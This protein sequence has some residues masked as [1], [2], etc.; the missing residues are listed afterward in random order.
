MNS[1]DS[2]DAALDLLRRLN[3]SRLEHH[4]KNLI[5]L[6]PTLAEDL[7]SSVD[8]PLTIKRDPKDSQKEYLCCDYNRDA[9]SH[10]SPWSNE[11]FPELSEQDLEESPFPSE[12]LRK[13][14]ILF[15][16]SFDVYRD[17]YYEGGISSAYLWDVA[18]D[19]SNIVRDFAGVVL[20]KK[21][22][23]SSSSWDSIHVLEATFE[24]DNEVTYRITTTILLRLDKDNSIKLSGNLSR[25][26]EKTV[27]INAS[28][29]ADQINIAH[30]TN[31]GS[32][33][34]DIEYQMRILLEAVY[35]E[36]TRDIFH[37]TKN[38]AVSTEQKNKTAHEE[39]IKGLQS[40]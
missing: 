29:N 11:Y 25:Q 31:V 34:E 27:T 12:P 19:T 33:I 22:N 8:I 15:N 17:L 16:D 7:L 40:L 2:Y 30:I 18:D 36:K 14:E 21:S 10:R 26:T 28:N 13:L 6:E 39:I 32:M 23:Q 3:P 4:L 37:E 1:E 5:Q 20:F 9:D 24:N 35:F 38:G